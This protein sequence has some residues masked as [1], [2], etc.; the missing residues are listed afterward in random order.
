MT[1]IGHRELI[2]EDPT[3][4]MVHLNFEVGMNNTKY[5]DTMSIQ[6]NGYRCHKVP[7]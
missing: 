2:R 6:Q 4:L 5:E 3:I 7:S 1:T